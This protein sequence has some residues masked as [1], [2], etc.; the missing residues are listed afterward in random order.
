[1]PQSTVGLRLDETTQQ[2]LKALSKTRDR[3]PHYL[4]KEAV[5]RYLTVEEQ[6]EAERQLMRA[7]WENYE[8]TGKTIAHEK[9]EKWAVSLSDNETSS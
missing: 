7:R 3:S 4:M 5:E 2:R 6:I 9:I 8:I 1:M